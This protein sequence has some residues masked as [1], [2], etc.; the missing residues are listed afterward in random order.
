MQLPFGLLNQSFYENGII[1]KLNEQKKTIHARSIFTKG[2]LFAKK[3]DP[4][5]A[6]KNVMKAVNLAKEL[7]RKNGQTL[8]QFATNFALSLEQINSI[9]IGVDAPEQLAEISLHS[10][11]LTKDHELDLLHAAI[12]EIAPNDVRPERWK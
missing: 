9:I 7:S 4:A 6:S 3:A 5:Q 1:K 8:M 12:T 2:L 10:D 11:N